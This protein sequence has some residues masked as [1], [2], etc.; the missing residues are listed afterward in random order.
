MTTYDYPDTRLLIN[1]EWR[2]GSNNETINVID[3]ATEEIIGTVACAS[4]DDLEEIATSL[5][6]G[7]IVWRDM[8]ALAR[9]QIM[10]KAAAL[11]RERS[12]I[13]AWL[14]TREAGKPLAQ[15]N[16]E[17]MNS[18]DT[19]EWFAEEGRRVYGQ[20]VPARTPNISQ[21]VIKLPIG[22]TAAFTPWNF[23]ISQIARKLGAALAAG[24][25]MVVK[26]P[27][28]TPAS[29][30]AFIQCFI[31]AGLPKGVVALVFGIPTQISE[32][33]IPHPVIEKIS[34]TGSTNIG[35][36]LAS[37]I[38]RSMKRST[39]ELGGHAPVLVFPDADLDQAVN[40]MIAAKFRNAGQ[41]CVSPTRFLIHDSIYD[42]YLDKFTQAC[43]ALKVGV[44]LA[45]ETD[46]GPLA[47]ARRIPALEAM[48]QDAVDKGG[49]L[50]FGGTRLGNKGYFF[51]PTIL[52][53]V[54]THAILM[55]EEPFGPLALINRFKKLDE[56]ISEGNRLRY[57][58]ASYAF[59]NCAKTIHQL[60]MHLNAG[61]L[62]I[63]HNGLGIPEV[64]FGGIKDS[65]YGTEG[66]S[67]AIQPYMD[68][69]YVSLAL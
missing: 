4:K 43:A 30:A 40:V 62:T 23:P 2:N 51:A 21:R 63:N 7:F 1:N 18:A 15:A 31:D 58:L 38:G 33:F 20:I 22:P 42:T 34:F 45:P 3:P 17:I 49:R 54:P 29:P 12:A 19:I 55:N 53:D 25:S 64:P 8:G 50:H 13:I 36:H 68:L 39:M 60:T 65:G 24:C 10:R 41:V 44:G 11:L 27:E 61:M 57:G 69:K 52:C 5:A 28:E 47:N 66:G 67:E 37:L 16:L 32:F 59:T 48:I 56:A 46:M 35:K 6:E 14:M 26:A 9:S